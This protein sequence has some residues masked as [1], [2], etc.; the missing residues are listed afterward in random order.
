MFP[1]FC[2]CFDILPV[3]VLF[4]DFDAADS[5]VRFAGKPDSGRVGGGRGMI[6]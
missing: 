6:G 5:V 4:L 1:V 3:F 2:A